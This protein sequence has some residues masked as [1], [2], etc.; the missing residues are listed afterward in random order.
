[1]SL[2]EKPSM[3]SCPNRPVWG[4]LMGHLGKAT[5]LF[6]YRL[7]G[8]SAKHLVLGLEPLLANRGRSW[9]EKSDV[10]WRRMRTN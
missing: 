8:S 3:S 6:S 9:E 5:P 4:R 7:Y 2:S 10:D 1:M